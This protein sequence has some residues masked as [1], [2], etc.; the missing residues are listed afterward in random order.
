VYAD[1]LCPICMLSEIVTIRAEMRELRAENADLRRWKALDKPLTAAMAV[2]NNDM[3]RLRTQLTEA[4]AFL[5]GQADRLDDMIAQGR[6]TPAGDEW[7]AMA[8]KLRGE[9]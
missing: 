6:R 1:G 9:R 2:V 7:R 8:R 4:A 3:Q 5:D